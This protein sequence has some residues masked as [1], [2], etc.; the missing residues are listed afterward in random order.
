MNE[1]HLTKLILY[2]LR[3]ENILSRSQLRPLFEIG[4]ARIGADLEEFLEFLAI[5]PAITE[6]ELYTFRER[7]P[8]LMQAARYHLAACQ[9]EGINLTALSDPDYPE[10]LDACRDAPF[11]LFYKGAL[12]AYNQLPYKLAIVGSRKMTGYG[13]RF[14]EQEVSQ[15]MHYGIAIISGMAR[16]VDT[17]AHEICLKKQG[18]TAACLAHGLDLCYPSE[19]RHM[20]EK[21]AREGILFSEHAPGV[22]P[23]R[24]YFPARNRLISGLAQG[25]LVIEG[26]KKSGSL[27]TA[28]F[29]ASQGREVLAVPGSV[30]QPTSEGCNRLIR[31]GA[32]PILDYRDILVTLGI[33]LVEAYGNKQKS[34]LS[35]L[36]EKLET[37]D[38][39]EI[40]LS[41]AL[42]MP[43]TELKQQLVRLEADGT[44]QYRQGRYFLTRQ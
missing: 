39:S 19:H 9:R 30:F 12:D 32:M 26:G 42:T 13:I 11:I 37:Q 8:Q 4:I 14:A 40:E 16:G 1:E 17:K 28:E 35:P 3:R 18:F 41:D 22:E 6:P 15:L 10:L 20:K 43:L 7:W 31:D 33:D 27:I 2:Q 21:I 25:V 24:S 44:I 23:L 5:N 38:Y 36:L 34:A 29:A